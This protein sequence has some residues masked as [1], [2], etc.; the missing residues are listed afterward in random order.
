M[1]LQIVKHSQKRYLLNKF[2]S[3][4]KLQILPQSID[5]T[6]KIG[7]LEISTA[8]FV[9]NPK[10]IEFVTEL[11]SIVEKNA[12]KT[13]ELEEI[14][15][16]ILEI[17]SLYHSTY[18]QLADIK[19]ELNNIAEKYE[20]SQRRRAEIK[21]KH[22]DIVVDLQLKLKESLN[23]PMPSNN[24]D[25]FNIIEESRDQIQLLTKDM[26]RKIDS[27]K[28]VASEKR[29]NLDLMNKRN[30]ELEFEIQS[31][32]NELEL[33]EQTKDPITIDPQSEEAQMIQILK[34]AD[35]QLQES[36]NTI[37]SQKEKIMNLDVK[38]IKYR[39]ILSRQ[40]E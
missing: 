40:D 31:L 10:R 15:K 18:K 16:K 2:F 22:R 39:A 7:E 20:I 13:A 6:Y 27:M 35:V 23:K 24:V 17:E 5:K 21:L 3:K 12:F 37:Q 9:Y 4:W 1:L 25:K 36:V 32:Q 26:S 28:E 29:A 8:S 38:I 11:H 34:E 19:M 30:E 14:E 33:L